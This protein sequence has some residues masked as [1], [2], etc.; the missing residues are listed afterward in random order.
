MLSALSKQVGIVLVVP[1]GLWITAHTLSLDVRGRRRYL[2]LAVYGCAVFAPFLVLVVRYAAASELST[3][4]YYFYTYNREVYG[5]A[6]QGAERARVLHDTFLGRF[7]F[8][9]VCAPVIGLSAARILA[10][11]GPHKTRLA[12]YA[13]SGFENTVLLGFSTTLLVSNASLRNF[14]HYYLQTIPW[15][16]LLG[17]LVV[18][19][20][21]RSFTED[22]ELSTSRIFG[23]RSLVLLPM[24]VVAGLGWHFRKEGHRSDKDLRASLA[25]SKSPVCKFLRK[26]SSS[27]D[28]TFIWG[29]DP[30]PYTACERR[31]ASR[32]V[33]TTFVAGY[34]PWIGASHEVE[35]ARATPHSRELLI[36]D[37]EREKPPVIFDS[38]PS[39]AGHSLMDIP[40]LAQYVNDHYCQAR[41]KITPAAYLR[42]SADHCPE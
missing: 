14:P 41:E 19:G 1:F 15:A 23:M 40:V 42:K 12:A 20:A 25:L 35:E 28:T 17:G 24:I 2:P 9:L 16:A 29:F 11:R 31:P 22:D 37:L 5:G 39:L 21:L 38:A 30:A 6:L 4:W 8:I 32:Y 3:F 33:F 10:N 7:D 34:V 36:E 27:A 18:E 13:A 26:H